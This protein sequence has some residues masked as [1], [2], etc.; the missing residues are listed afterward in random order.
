MPKLSSKPIIDLLIVVPSLE[1]AKDWI[2][3]LNFLGYVFWD[4]N[5]DK[6]HLRFFKG[7]PP[8]GDKRTHHVHLVAKGHEII[9]PRL[10]FRDGL[11]KNAKIRLEYELL[12]KHLAELYPLDREAY[13]DSKADFI[14]RVLKKK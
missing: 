9:K 6:E 1:M 3:P 11:R 14:G 10:L 5:P 13:T 4:E 12:K 8:F 7:M 2:K